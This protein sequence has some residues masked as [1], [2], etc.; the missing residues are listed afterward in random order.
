[1]KIFVKNLLQ[2]LDFV[3]VSGDLE[4]EVKIAPVPAGVN[5]V[6]PAAVVVAVR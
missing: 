3:V 2:H 4:I 5:P 6:Y 1:M